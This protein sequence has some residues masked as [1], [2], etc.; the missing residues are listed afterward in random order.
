MSLLNVSRVAPTGAAC[1]LLE[2]KVVR[3]DQ[4]G[5]EDSVFP[6]EQRAVPGPG[7]ASGGLFIPCLQ[8]RA[9]VASSSVT[10]F[11]DPQE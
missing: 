11:H 4:Q 2:E 7:Q 3:S 6:R 9:K 10:H 5:L 8:G 1:D